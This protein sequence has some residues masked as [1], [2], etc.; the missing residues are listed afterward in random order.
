MCLLV[1]LDDVRLYT[2]SSTHGQSVFLGPCPDLCGVSFTVRGGPSDGTA[3]S[4]HFSPCLNI[5]RESSA[6]FV[7]VESVEVDLVG[8]AVE[9]K[10]NCFVCIT[11]VQVIYE[12]G[13]SFDCHHENLSN[14]EDIKPL[15]MTARGSR[16][17]DQDQ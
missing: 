1:L 4:F 14:L 17:Q 16:G 12:N 2:S 7:R 15:T 10:M 11:A 5:R 6:K 13:D 3:T 9:N 8:S